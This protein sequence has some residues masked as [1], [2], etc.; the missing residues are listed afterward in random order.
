MLMPRD[1]AT[2]CHTRYSAATLPP[3]AA[4]IIY[5]TLPACRA[6]TLIDADCWRA[7]TLRRCLLL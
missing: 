4:P 1:A 6:A 3:D 2:P 7:I 5:V